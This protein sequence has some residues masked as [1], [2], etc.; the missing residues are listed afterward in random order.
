MSAAA[1]PTLANALTELGG[2]DQ[3]TVVYLELRKKGVTRGKRGEDKVIYGDDLVQV[4]LWSG[5]SYKALVERSFKKLHEYWGRG[6]LV[7]R[8]IAAAKV[9]DRD[10]VT[11]QDAA[12]AIQELEDS[13]LRVIRSP[14]KD[15][16]DPPDGEFESVWEPL[17][18]G[19]ERIRG[20]KV[21]VGAGN[22]DDHRAPVPGTVYMDGVKLGE[23]ILAPA[24]N[25]AW[26]SRQKP[27]SVAKEILR[28][29][30]PVGLYARYSLEKEN[31]LTVKVGAEASAMAKTAKVPI[32]PEAIRSLFKVA[33]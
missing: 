28:S 23:K 33:P 9:E 20:A 29:W 27:K 6:D 30:L 7:T 14:D 26:A 8:L 22:P 10:D 25:G 2:T 11:V 31:R 15:D 4:L 16:T 32:D 18:V 1:E 19:G 21:Y 5:F 12:T 3:G 13:F 24:P 17:E